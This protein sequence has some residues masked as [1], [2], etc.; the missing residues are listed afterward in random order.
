MTP[1]C[2]SHTSAATGATSGRKTVAVLID[3][4]APFTFGYQAVIRQALTRH[5]QLLDVNL[6][7]VF[8]R[9]LDEPNPLAKTSNAIYYL[10]DPALFDGIIILSTTLAAHC[11]IETITEFVDRFR[12]VPR[13]SVGIALPNVPSI[14]TNNRHGMDAVLEHVLTDHE[15]RH[16]AFIGGPAWSPE[17]RLRQTAY[18]DAL[19]RHQIA[20]D[21]A[22][23]ACGDFLWTRG[24]AAMEELLARGLDI[25]AV[26]AAN[27][28]MAVGAISVLRK[29][30]YRVPKDIA[31]T[32]FDDLPSSS[33]EDPPMTT[34]AQPCALIARRALELVL[35][36]IAGRSVPEIT[37][38]PAALVVR[39][40]CG[41]GSRGHRK[42][43]EGAASGPLDAEVSTRGESGAC[44]KAPLSVGRLS[45][46]FDVSSTGEAPL[47][48]IRSNLLSNVSDSGLEDNA[49]LMAVPLSQ[50]DV[51]DLW[52][53]ACERVAMSNLRAQMNDRVAAERTMMNMGAIG[54]RVSGALDL[55]L[56][57]EALLEVLPAVGVETAYLSRCVDGHA[58]EL[59][60]FVALRNG[61]PQPLPHARFPI[62]K[63]LPP[64]A[65]PLDQRHTFAVFP[66]VSNIAIL[67]IV[68]FE[69]SEV[70]HGYEMIRDQVATALTTV[71]LHQAVVEQTK[72]HE[73]DVQEQERLATAKRMQALSVLAGGVAHDLNN[74][75]GPLVALPD[76][77]LRVLR[78]LDA[79][80]PAIR[81]LQADIRSIKGSALRAAQTIKDLLTLSRQGRTIKEPLDL[82][83]LMSGCLSGEALS[84]IRQINSEVEILVSIPSE[85]LIVRA[86]AAHL[87]RAVLNLVRNAVESI[88]G[89]GRVVVTLS[90]VELVEWMSGFE[91][92]EPGRYAVLSIADTGSGIAEP[93]LCRVFEPFVSRKRLGEQSGSGLGLAIVHGVIKEHAG[94]IDVS[95]EPGCG[96]TFTLYIPQSDE[97]AVANEPV[98]EL[99]RG[100]GRILV[101]DDDPTQLRT[102]RRV[103]LHL[104]YEADIIGTARQACAVFEKA[105]AT[106]QSPYDLVILDMMLDRGVDGLDVYQRIREL[107]PAQK[108]IMASG[109]AAVERADAAVQKGLLWLVKPYTVDALAEA[110][111]SVLAGGPHQQQTLSS[112]PP[113]Q[114]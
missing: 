86:S 97:M 74:V 26:V 56:V 66:L 52:A 29:R 110:V 62:G 44:A 23:I 91:R 94:F 3:Y 58:E 92:V 60:V 33:V 51:E 36:Q 46:P 89:A 65:Y 104:G 67:G 39:R 47:E 87:V 15:C 111:H 24:A 38:L 9:A 72:L 54:E 73:R 20:F 57:K 108:A 105:A 107:F 109:Y 99:P 113:R 50:E 70:N 4:L 32:G 84:T 14:I 100:R 114:P 11:G 35:D 41:C 31:V 80:Q 17:A 75:L 96:T 79:G 59:E 93:D 90:P 78:D 64:G 2:V 13:C 5:C 10:L 34:V 55:D 16:V 101:V 61:A 7:A 8:G 28:G 27:D 103:L 25:D 37:E 71:A 22:M 82:G 69:Y 18:Q 49:L 12:S 45:L 6:L 98:R 112:S 76:V 102:C 83:L 19:A 68:V 63:L 43:S 21:P 48:D 30:G 40:S 77:M 81:E 106:Q 95:S 85:P 53:D 88:E 42:R 1:E